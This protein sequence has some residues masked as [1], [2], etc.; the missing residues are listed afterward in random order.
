MEN[1]LNK[2]EAKKTLDSQSIVKIKQLVEEINRDAWSDDKTRLRAIAR[3][4]DEIL[5]IL[6]DF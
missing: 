6:L 1:Y 4:S 2:T 3:T 5:K